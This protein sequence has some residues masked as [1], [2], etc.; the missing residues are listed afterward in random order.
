MQG[1]FAL[2]QQGR[3]DEARA[4]YLE[5]LRLQPRHFDAL[6]LLGALEMQA[7]QYEKALEFLDRAIAA[8]A[9]RSAAYSN[10][11]NALRMLNR[12]QEA[13][14]R[15]DRALQLDPGNVAALVNRGLSL[16]DMERNAEALADLDRALA[17]APGSANILGNRGHVLRKLARFEAA[18]ACFSQLL[19]VAPE[20]EYARG[21]LLHMRLQTCDWTEYAPT[22]ERITASV[23]A[24]RRADYPFSF[25]AIARA[26]EDQRRCGETFV[27]HIH[28]GAPLPP[29]AA[30]REPG[31]R[32]RLAYLSGDFRE[33]AISYLMAGVFEQHDRDRFETIA[34]SFRPA[35]GG[36]TGRR[37]A[38]AFERFID[39]SQMNDR[40]VA[41]SLREMQ[42]DIAV[43]LMGFTN[44]S[45]T[46]ILAHRAAPVQVNYLGFPG[47]M[48]AGYMDYI[49]G[50]RFVIP[51]DRRAAY[52]EKVV[53][54]PD[55]FQAND[56]KRAIAAPMPS[57]Q[58]SGLPASG[59]IFCSFN[60]GY[61]INPDIFEV[62]MRLLAA[63]PHSVL[64]LV[65]DGDLARSNLR[66]EAV[67]SGI[68]PSRLIFASRLDY[69]RHLARLGLADLFLDTLPF[70]AGTTASDA[71]WAGVPV[72]TCA[73]EAFASRMSGA[74]LSATGLP[75][76]ITPSLEA[77][78]ASALD[79]ASHPER[80]AGLRAC[81]ARNRDTCALF[82]TRRFCR[83]LEEAYG[84]MWARHCRGEPPAD[85]ALNPSASQSRSWW[86]GLRG[87]VFGKA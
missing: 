45:R 13:I 6:H 8:D 39:V 70:N 25:L 35:D 48:G 54:L 19:A 33:H 66:R 87:R 12:P 14:G 71:L 36:A 20:H 5:V 58:E 84:E 81:L 10:L 42:V 76:L 4:G 75:E 38:A 34:V 24:G 44:G 57:R 16:R 41:A 22:V 83:N 43:D 46:P 31:G 78:E 18:A 32:I 7:A 68:D 17:L 82:D 69:P 80:L 9:S 77:Y 60:N 85:I 64:W 11:A 74:L 23:R 51:E 67:T 62:W 49:I 30:P 53:W 29:L 15:C 26:A 47:T 37:I 52:A 21:A 63:V 65:A 79:L 28:P 40:E 2:H 72:L 56:D 61:K 86:A 27:A 50:D 73:G 1:A 59:F 55:C 3:L